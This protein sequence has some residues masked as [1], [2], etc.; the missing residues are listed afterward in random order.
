MELIHTTYN[1]NYLPRPNRVNFIKSQI[2]APAHLTKSSFVIPFLN[3][4]QLVMA[5]NQRRGLEIPG[6]HVESDELLIRAAQRECLEETGYEINDLI[7]IG[8]LKMISEGIAP[9]GWKYPHPISY[10]QFFAGEINDQHNFVANDE[11]NLPVI[12]SIN[13]LDQL[14]EQQKMLITEAHKII[15]DG[16]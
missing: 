8:F 16:E 1:V 12:L 9:I 13:Q 7:P 5:N 14:N 2:M 15:Y 6:G 11:C 4:D 10:Q 3:S